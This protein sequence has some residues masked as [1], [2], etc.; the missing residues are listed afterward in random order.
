MRQ[1][2]KFFFRK[3]TKFRKTIF[4]NVPSFIEIISNNLNNKSVEEIILKCMKIKLNFMM[5]LNI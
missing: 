4:K 3:K 2:I 5:E 1:I